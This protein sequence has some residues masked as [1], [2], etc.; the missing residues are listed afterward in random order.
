MT[1]DRWIRGRTAW[2]LF[3]SVFGNSLVVLLAVIY[4]AMVLHL[5]GTSL[6][7]FLLLV[8]SVTVL[9]QVG[10]HLYA[11]ARLTTFRGLTSERLELSDENRLRATGEA[12]KF[13]DLISRLSLVGW[14]AGGG[15]V[16][17]LLALFADVP[18]MLALRVIGV[19][20]LFGPLSTVMVGLLATT[21]AHEAL[22]ALSEGLP[23]HVV[24]KAAPTSKWT[25]R[26]RILAFT[27]VLVVFPS[28]MLVDVA[29]V[30]SDAAL[31]ELIA[32]APDQRAALAAS[33]WWQFAA[34]LAVLASAAALLAIAAAWGGGSVI[35][36]P[37]Q[38]LAAQ[39]RRVAQGDLSR[40][41]VIAADGEVWLVTGVFARLHERLAVLVGQLTR[42]GASLASATSTL[43][44]TSARYEATAAEQ[45]AALN[46]TSAT[47]EELAHSARQ[48][49]SSAAS[50]QDLAQRTLEAAENG[51][52]DAN[53]FQAAVERMKQDNRSIAG[54]V[55]RLQRRVQQIGRIVELINTV[56]DRS[57][58]LALS[59]E[60]EGSRA[61]DVGRGFSLVGAEMRRLAENVLESTAE[62]EELIAEIR[63]ATMTTAEA[64]HNGSVLTEGS[65]GLA[66]EVT[67][68]LSRVG[69]LARETSHQ[70][71]TISL[72]TQQQQSGTD[73]LAETMA[74][75]LAGTQ[76]SLAATRQLGSANSRLVE[77]AAALRSVVGR[78]TGSSGSGA[79]R[80]AP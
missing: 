45:A 57:D 65:T 75:I 22:D 48:I 67:H 24:I 15:L 77:L 16:S 79:G 74:D 37:M 64:T 4:S 71:R 31:S 54:A 5:G 20:L 80:E 8:V 43:H 14:V 70:V 11:A 61:G 9:L 35:V 56:A 29:R 17:A 7:I 26:G 2:L 36:R 6:Q 55:E 47:T 21:R 63:D 27:F 44:Q 18:G 53:A 25:V 33:L 23:A 34:R 66:A 58:L 38:K 10:L 13:P 30:F 78:F 19:A 40:P 72:A 49:A 28:V 39:A 62:V 41:Q 52:D 60:L 69:E 46:Q 76:Q 32:A 51:Q 12:W 59:A 73:Q 68:A 50:V 42:A 1:L 3:P